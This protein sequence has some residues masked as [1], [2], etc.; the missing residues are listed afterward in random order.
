MPTFFTNRKL[1]AIL[2]NTQFPLQLKLMVWW[3]HFLLSKVSMKILQSTPAQSRKATILQTLIF[4]ILNLLSIQKQIIDIFALSKCA[5]L[6]MPNIELIW[7]WF[8]NIHTCKNGSA[9]NHSSYSC[10]LHFWSNS[11]HICITWCTLF[12]QILQVSVQLHL[13]ITIKECFLD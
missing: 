5:K 2:I 9:L 10:F 6:W 12:H 8:C 7:I 1:M 13:I 4:N 11:P 3:A